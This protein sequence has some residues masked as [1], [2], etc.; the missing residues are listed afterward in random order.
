MTYKLVYLARRAATVTREEWPRTWKSHAVF[1]SQFPVLEAKID[2]MRYC[3]R[4]D[5]ELPGFS[6]AHDGVAVAASDCLDGLT[7]A[8]FS[9]ADRALIDHDERRVFDMLTPNFTWYCEEVPLLD[10]PL[11]EVA[12]FSFLA[13]KPGMTH[14]E[15]DARWSGAH[16][17]VARETTG[18]TRYVHNRPI[19]DPLPL[20]PFDG[21][22]E[23]WFASTAQAEAALRSLALDPLRRDLAEFCDFGQS[24]VMLTGTCHC[25]PKQ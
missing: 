23:A 20:F 11:G 18:M 13:R 2:W 10:G 16:A 8:G 4:I 5:T 25:W 14:A 12:A 22:A 21:I 17:K 1:A 15:F 9:D 19:H 24:V 7:G 3:N 6:A